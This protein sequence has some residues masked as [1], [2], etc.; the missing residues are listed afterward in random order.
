MAKRTLPPKTNVTISDLASEMLRRCGLSV[1]HRDGK[2]L[3]R[4]SLNEPAQVF[5]RDEFQVFAL[6]HAL[7]CLKGA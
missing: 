2:F 1:G 7:S 5:D 4:T 6:E 3:V